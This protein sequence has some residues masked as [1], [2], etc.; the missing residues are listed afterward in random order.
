[1]L[2]TESSSGGKRTVAVFQS[3]LWERVLFPPDRPDIYLFTTRL[4]TYREV[5]KESGM[6]PGLQGIMGFLL[7]AL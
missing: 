7:C 5:G 3:V 1:M 4:G 6:G 2:K